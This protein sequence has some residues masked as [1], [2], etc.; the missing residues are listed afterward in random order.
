M[1]IDKFKVLLLF[2]ISCQRPT[3]RCSW[4]VPYKEAEFLPIYDENSD[5]H[6]MNRSSAGLTE[7]VIDAKGRTSCYSSPKKERPRKGSFENIRQSPL[8]MRFNDKV[9]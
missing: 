3:I 5:R 4:Q 6:S 1:V 7:V 9:S 2:I 8:G